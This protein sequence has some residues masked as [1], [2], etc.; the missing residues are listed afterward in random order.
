[1]S[2]RAR[3]VAG[4]V[5]LLAVAALCAGN[6]RVLALAVPLLVYLGA[7]ILSRPSVPRLEITRS[8]SSSRVRSGASVQVT[9]S[10]RNPGPGID[11]I[12]ITD[13]VPPSLSCAGGSPRYF[14]RLPPG[15]SAAWSYTVSTRR[16]EHR[17]QVVAT[18]A[19]GHV[20]LV[21]WIAEHTVES[22]LTVHP[23]LIRLPR[24]VVRP[25]QTRGFAGPLPSRTTGAGIT[26]QGVRDY[27]AGDPLR[28]INWRRSSRSADL[29]FTNEFEPERIADIGIVL[30]ARDM[31]YPPPSAAL[32]EA[33][34]LA[35][36]SLAD[37]FLSEGNRV[38]LL[39]YGHS[40]ER[41]Q[42]GYGKV[43]RERIRDQLARARPGTNYALQSLAWL[44]TRMFPARSQIVLVSPGHPGDL[45]VLVAMRATGYSV[46]LVSPDPVAGEERSR[47]QEGGSTDTAQP[48]AALRIAR[49]E[50]ALLLTSLRRAG[51]AVIDWECGSSPAATLTGCLARQPLF[52][53]KGAAR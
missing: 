13:Q 37:L 34:V 28:W 41:V 24:V 46:A 10:V 53:R 27:R 9:V 50:R 20:D 40:W 3:L 5:F 33:A 14:T 25:R 43:Q 47:R 51:V 21:G 45:A 44:P 48:R 52:V 38:A 19:R 18:E 36:G 49:L 7:G 30:D 35:A 6:G 29:L 39:V 12:V 26:F 42:P 32:F 1:V 23:Q 8:L 4:L 17:W 31:S 11:E 15:S 22:S 16:G 2:G